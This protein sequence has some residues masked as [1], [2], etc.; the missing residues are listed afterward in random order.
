MSTASDSE[1]A[2]QL[3]DL[4][5]SLADRGDFAAAIDAYRRAIALLPNFA[6][7]Y[8]NLGA[9]L[10]DAGRV[11]EALAAHKR[12]VELNPRSPAALNNLGVAL[13]DAGWFADAIKV[14]GAATV[15]D[16]NYAEAWTNLGIAHLSNRDGAQALATGRR[17]I[18]IDPKLAKARMNYAM[19]LLATGNL[20]DGFIE[21]EWRFDC[22][23]HFKRRQLDRPFWDGTPMPNGTLL[24]HAEQ[25]FGDAIHFVRYVRRARELCNRV[26]L[27]IHSELARLMSEMADSVVSSGEPLPAFDAHCSTM[28]LPAILKL[29][30][31]DASAYI[32]PRPKLVAI[33]A[34]RLG[35]YK[36]PRVGICHRGRPTHSNDQHRSMP[37]D[38]P[39]ELVRRDDVSWVNLLKRMGSLSPAPGT[40]GAGEDGEP[41]GIDFTEGLNDFADTAALIANLDLVISVD[42]AVAHLAAAMGKPCWI[43]LPYVAEWR[44]MIHGDTSPWYPSVR[45]FRQSRF[46]DW[47]DVVS[48]VS[49]ALD[50]FNDGNSTA[51]T[52]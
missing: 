32:K 11:D 13:N 44:W 12:S 6:A 3:N 31:H 19:I 37:V 40:P 14:F 36:R 24:V 42:T 38:V 30:S 29:E 18:E 4:G 43:M 41:F 21:H 22:H 28:S 47:S 10:R 46:A 48:R 33:W 16:P 51:T 1:A 20:R 39:R 7:A 5:N 49:A 35:Q 8:S 27:E 34:D 9:A 2:Y 25:G 50:E 17:A 23:W 26:V 45:L 15:Y 52:L